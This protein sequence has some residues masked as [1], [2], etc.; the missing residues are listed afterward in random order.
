MLRSLV[1]SEMCIRDRYQ[2][3]VRGCLGPMKRARQDAEQEPS[4][5]E[6][7]AQSLI[8]A[9]RARN[10]P[11]ASTSPTPPAP[12]FSAGFPGLL[13]RAP[14]AGPATD[15][16]KPVFP[17]LFSQAGGADG[18]GAKPG[19]NL[20]FG[21]KPP[22]FGSGTGKFSGLT[23]LTKPLANLV[24][25]EGEGCEKKRFWEIKVKGSLTTVREGEVGGLGE[26]VDK[27]HES[28][29]IA[30][31]FA[32]E[33][34]QGQKDKGWTDA[35]KTE[36]LKSLF[37][38]QDTAAKPLGSLFGSF[39]ENKGNKG[40]AVAA[41]GK[42]TGSLTQDEQDKLAAKARESFTNFKMP[43]F[44][45]DPQTGLGS[46]PATLSFGS[47]V[48]A[49][50][51]APTT[52][53]PGF[54]SLFGSAG[55]QQSSFDGSAA[56]AEAQDLKEAIK[57]QESLDL[58]A[59]VASP[60]AMAKAMDL[61]TVEV[62]SGEE[63]EERLLQVKDAKLFVFR[64]SGAGTEDPG[65]WKELG[66]GSLNVNRNPE[67]QQ[68]RIVMR[69]H[70]TK[71]LVLNAA[72]GA[73]MPYKF[74]GDKECRLSCAGLEHDGTIQQHLIKVMGDPSGPKM[75]HDVLTKAIAQASN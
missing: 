27:Q 15:A 11:K 8:D 58:G 13:S 59:T 34:I 3:R 18:E 44:S 48:G 55:E 41:G 32:E 31:T 28:D 36:P 35:P 2:R 70:E 20:S 53:A 25:P 19:L 4:D 54:T 7:Q 9:K 6:P 46:M 1:G 17:G 60:T 56:E 66:R 49:A 22:V 10:D 16:T 37:G 14:A 67:T 75:L 65:K 61:P 12:A 50:V 39:S 24:S 43:A 57:E 45:A 30:Q 38:T 5:P 52:G 23:F 26:T 29:A 62:K 71:Q 42:P 51:T 21:S 68:Q 72:I 69:R 64:K 74:V 33:Q 47:G 63:S 73:G 40:A